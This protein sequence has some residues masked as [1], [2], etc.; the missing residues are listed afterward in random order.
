MWIL[1]NSV[2]YEEKNNIVCEMKFCYSKTT[3]ING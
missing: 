1:E 3:I 2:K